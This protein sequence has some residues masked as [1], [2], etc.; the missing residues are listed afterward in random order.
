MTARMSDDIPQPH[1]RYRGRTRRDCRPQPVP[2][3]QTL[4]PAPNAV[5]TR[6]AGWHD[7]GDERPRWPTQEAALR[8]R[9]PGLAPMALP[10][11]VLRAGVRAATPRPRAPS[12]PGRSVTVRKIDGRRPPVGRIDAVLLRSG[13]RTWSGRTARTASAGGPPPPG[14]P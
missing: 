1:L 12:A 2:H 7:R 13:F 8:R 10:Q 11:P 4:F 14:L 3:G 5:T 9:P 6:I